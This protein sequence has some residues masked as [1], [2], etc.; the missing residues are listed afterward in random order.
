MQ[1]AVDIVNDS[2]HPTNKIAATIAGDGWA[3]SQTNQWPSIIEEKIGTETDIGNSS[4]TIHAE[5]ACILKANQTGHR[6]K[7]ASI[8][9]SDPPCPNCMK[10]M[11][12]AGISKLYIDHKGFDK[13]WAKRRGDSF[14]NMS[15]RV[16]AKAGMDV[17]VIYRK[18]QRFEIISEHPPGYKPPNENPPQI[19]LCNNWQ[20]KLESAISDHDNEPFALALAEDKD[21]KTVSILLDRHPTI[22][23]TM[24]DVEGKHGKYSFIL[25][26]INRLLMVAAREGLTLNP[27]HIFSSRVPTSREFVNLIGAGFSKIQIG[28]TNESRDEYGLQAFKQLKLDK[29]IEIT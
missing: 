18:E 20:S 3:F 12:E 23:Y 8:F 26:P 5:T 7:N 10:N 27:D 16:A 17:H 13:D 19:E 6:T 29:I 24:E 4:G 1:A 2:Q 28:N 25:Q 21:G 15:M 22:G 9:I 14:E 11:A